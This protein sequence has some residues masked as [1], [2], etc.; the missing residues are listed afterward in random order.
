VQEG[1]PE[2]LGVRRPVTSSF[3]S[4]HASSAVFAATL[5]SEGH[6]RRAPLWFALAGVVAASRPYAKLHHTSD[7][8]AG[9]AT[10]LTLAL[11]A[12][13]LWPRP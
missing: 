13:R 11:V 2:R 10:G 12:R 8:V 3:P 9:A 6:T 7:V 4:G 1:E 5:L